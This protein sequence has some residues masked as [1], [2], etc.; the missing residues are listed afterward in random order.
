M[1]GTKLQNSQSNT[2]PINGIKLI[3][4]HHAEKFTSCSLF[5]EVVIKRII[6]ITLATLQN[7]SPKL[8]PLFSSENTTAVST[9]NGI[10]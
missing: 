6:A 5:E 4:S 9:N 7:R 8:M 2:E 1:P 10:L 3:S